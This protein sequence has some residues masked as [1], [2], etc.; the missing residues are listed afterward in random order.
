MSGSVAARWGRILSQGIPT[1][2]PVL[3]PI[4]VV[5]IAVGIASNK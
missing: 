5:L 2:W 3:F 4:I 1:A